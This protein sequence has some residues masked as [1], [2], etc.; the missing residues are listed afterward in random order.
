MLECIRSDLIGKFA[1]TNKNEKVKIH[2]DPFIK[3]DSVWAVVE[4][5]SSR[6]IIYIKICTLTL[7]VN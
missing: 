6:Q 7:T 3:D 5:V 1:L 4:Y 2:S